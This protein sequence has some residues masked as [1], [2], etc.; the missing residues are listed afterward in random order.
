MLAQHPARR[1]TL[2]AFVLAALF[3][4]LAV[5]PTAYASLAPGAAVERAWQQ[6]RE[7]GAFAWRS[8]VTLTS[9]P[10][11]VL[12]N[13]GLNSTSQSL[14]AVGS[15]DFA[16]R[17]LELRLGELEGNLLNGAAGVELRVEDG[18]SRA[19]VDGGDWQELPGVGELFAPGAD[20]LGYL[21]AAEQVRLVGETDG[22]TQYA[23]E[24]SGPAFA[25]YMRAQLEQSLRDRGKLPAGVTVQTPEAY[26]ELRGSGM[27][28][29]GAD[30]L[31]RRQQISASL[32]LP[33]TSEAADVV[34]THS[35]SEFRE[36]VF[37]PPAVSASQA[38]GFGLNAALLVLGLLAAG[39]LIRGARS[40]RLYRALAPFFSVL[41]LLTPLLQTQPAAVAAAAVEE[42]NAE[43]AQAAEL[44]QEAQNP[45]AASFNP[46][47]QPGLAGASGTSGATG[48]RYDEAIDN[49]VDGDGDGLADA[50]EQQLGTSPTAK[51]SDGDGL[52][53]GV[54]VLEL[55][56]L[57]LQGDS[58]ADGLGDAQEVGGFELAGRRW[59]LDPLAGDTNHDGLPDGIEC[60]GDKGGAGRITLPCVDTDRDGLADVFDDDNDGD[61]LS[62]NLDTAPLTQI[63]PPTA[64]PNDPNTLSL[65]LAGYEPNRPLFVDFTVRPTAPAHLFYAGNVLDW[66]SGDRDGQ[67]QR[68]F[69]TTFGNSGKNANGDMRLVP[70]LEI[71]IPA[72]DGSFADLPTKANPSVGPLDSATLTS[73]RLEAWYDTWLDRNRLQQLGIT[74]RPKSTD[75]TL[76]A[77]VPLNSVRDPITGDPVA[78]SARMLYQPFTSDFGP[79]HKVRLIWLI[80]GM[81]DSCTAVPASFEPGKPD[82]ERRE[83]WC[84][85]TANWR[86]DP[87]AVL[88]S[89]YD[90][91]TVADLVVRED[92]GVAVAAAFQE[93]ATF[94]DPAGALPFAQHVFNLARGLDQTFMA[95]RVG[96]DGKSR[97]LTIA[98]LKAR[99]DKGQSC[100]NLVARWQ[101]PCDA[102]A[103][104]TQALTT[105]ADLALLPAYYLPTWLTEVYGGE[106]SGRAVSVREPTVLLARE[107]RARQ[108]A[109]SMGA[110]VV[111][112]GG[113]LTLRFDPQQQPVVMAGMALASYRYDEASRQ[114][115]DFP[116]DEAWNR[117]AT[118]YGD[119][120][121]QYAPWSGADEAGQSLAAGGAAFARGLFY[122]FEQGAGIVV[123]EGGRPSRLAGG[124][125]DLAQQPVDADLKFAATEP[126]ALAEGALALATRVIDL[127]R[128][129]NLIGA[130]T[131]E[132]LLRAV[133]ARQLWGRQSEPLGLLI[134]AAD[135]LNADDARAQS[136]GLMAPAAL[137]T[138]QQLN[139]APAAPLSTM[140]RAMEIGI[141]AG[142][143]IHKSYGLYSTI[144][145]VREANK[146]IA[147]GTSPYQSLV[148]VSKQGFAGK[149]LKLT[150]GRMTVLIT[151]GLAAFQ[152]YQLYS[153]YSQEFRA[154]NPFAYGELAGQIASMVA[155]T[156]S[157][158]VLGLV[159]PL[160][161]IAVAVLGLVD[162][163]LGATCGL[164]GAKGGICEGVTAWVTDTVGKF[165]YDAKPYPQLDAKDLMSIANWRITPK[166]ANGPKGIFQEGD[167]LNVQFDVITRL[168]ANPDLPATKLAPAGAPPGEV[169]F[170]PIDVIPRSNAGYQIVLRERN[171]GKQDLATGESN[172]GMWTLEP[173]QQRLVNTQ[174]VANEEIVLQPGINWKPGEVAL[175][176]NYAV[177][178]LECI[179]G[180]CSDDDEPIRKTSFTSLTEL[181]R[182]DVFPATL[183]RFYALEDRANGAGSFALAWDKQ[184]P[185]LCDA[186][187]DGL[188][189]PGCKGNDPADN[190][191][192]SDGDG[193]SD[194]YEVGNGSRGF[195]P[196][197]ADSDDDGLDDGAELRYGAD[198]GKADSDGDGLKDGDEIA[199]LNR[200]GSWAGGWAII[201]GYDAAGAPLKSYVSS[202]PLKAD[203]DDDGMLDKEEYTYGFNPRAFNRLDVLRVLTRIDE[204]DGRRD[205]IVAAGASVDYS[206]TIDNATRNRYAFGLLESALPPGVA[207]S[208]APRPYTLAPGASVTLGGALDLKGV[209]GSQKLAIVNRAGAIIADP[210][211]LTGGRVLWLHFDEPAGATRFADSSLFGND[212]SCAPG[213]CPV[214]GVE[215]YAGRAL[216]FEQDAA[217]P[218]VAAG[219][220]LNPQLRTITLWVRPKRSGAVQSLLA[221]EDY[222]LV[223]PGDSLRL[224]LLQNSNR[225]RTCF[226]FSCR[227]TS[228]TTTIDSAGELLEGQWN[229]VTITYDGAQLALYLNG[230]LDSRK[231]L[232]GPL[233]VTSTNLAIGR[234]LKGAL[235]ELAIY[236]RALSEAE[237]EALVGGPVLRLGFE[238]SLVDGSAMGQTV[239][240]GGDG[241]LR[242]AAERNGKVLRFDQRSW[243]ETAPHS[244]LD[245]GKGQG[246]FSFALWMQPAFA[247][248]NRDQDWLGVLG[249]ENVDSAGKPAGYAPSLFVNR[250]GDSL[251]VSFSTEKQRALP[252]SV[253][254]GP[255]LTPGAWQHVAVSYD[256][257]TFVFY[258]DGV[259]RARKP[260]DG[261]CAGLKPLGGDRIRIGRVDTRATITVSSLWIGFHNEDGVNEYYLT[262]AAAPGNSTRVWGENTKNYPA[263]NL[264]TTTVDVASATD[265][266]GGLPK[267]AVRF[268]LWESDAGELGRG[269]DDLLLD[270][271]APYRAPASSLGYN[272]AGNGKGVLSVVVQQSGFVGGLDD[273]RVYRHAL[274][275][276]EAREAFSGVSQAMGLALDEAPGAQQFRD[277][278]GNNQSALCSGDAC[279]Q[280]GL[281]GRVGQA[282]AFDG[283]DAIRVLNAPALNPASGLSVSAWVKLENPAAN[284]KIVSKFEERGGTRTG[285]ILGVNEGR[286]FA[287]I[288]DVDGRYASVKGGAVRADTWTHV[289]FTANPG[290]DLVGYVDGQPVGRTSLQLARKNIATV[291]NP[292]VILYQGKNFDGASREL[293]ADLNWLGSD[294]NDR[295]GSVRVVDA[296]V[297]FFTD[298]DYRGEQLGPLCAEQSLD[299]WS[300]YSCRNPFN[301]MGSISS[302]RVLAQKPVATG[303]GLR[304]TGANGWPSIPAAPLG[305]PALETL[306]IAARVK[307]NRL[308]GALLARAGWQMMI[309]GAEV[310]LSGGALGYAAVKAPLK[311]GVWQHV[312]LTYD[313]AKVV[314]YVDG[315]RAGESSRS[316]R[317][318]ESA[319][320]SFAINRG[321]ALDGT[322]KDLVLYARALDSGEIGELSRSPAGVSSAAR[323][324]FLPFDEPA[325]SAEFGTPAAAALSTNS[326][327]LTIGRASWGD[328]GVRGLIDEVTV[329]QGALTPE[330]IRAQ[331]DAAP[332][333]N[334]PLDE[335]LG[336]TGFANS[337]GAPAGC[338]GDACPQAG[339]KGRIRGA[340]VF[341]GVDDRV[342]TPDSAALDLGRYTVSLWVRPT[343]IKTTQD[344]TLVSKGREGGP[345][346]Y[347]LRLLAG[348]LR[349]ASST[350]CGTTNFSTTSRRALNQDQWNHVAVTFD[351]AQQQI[352][353]NGSL[354]ATVAVGCAGG[355]AA[356]NDAPLVLGRH[357]NNWDAFAGL[358]DEVQLYKVALDKAQI[359]RM[360]EY[361]ASW[362]DVVSSRNLSVDADNPVVRLDIGPA[363]TLPVG[364]ATIL[365]IYARDAGSPIVA[366]EYDAGAGWQSAGR[367]N[368]FWSLAYTP[369]AA[370]GVTIRL[371]A[372]DSVGHT[373]EQNVSLT[374]GDA[375]PAPTVA[376][377][378][379][380]GAAVLR[381]TPD[382]GGKAWK[383]ALAGTAANALQVV[384]EIRTL[385]G[386]V[387]GTPLRVAPLDGAWQGDYSFAAAPAGKYRLEVVATGVGGASARASAE[388]LLDN[389]AP[390][391][392][393]GAAP[394]E[395]GGAGAG[396]TLRGVVFDT[397]PLPVPALALRFEDA[398]ACSGAAC[399]G[400]QDGRIGSAAGFDG[401]DDG[402]DATINIPG[403]PFT[404]A[405]WLKPGDGR[406]Q[407]ALSAA[408]TAAANP[409]LRLQPDGGTLRAW[410][411]VD[412]VERELAATGFAPGE[413]RHAA[414]S[415]DGATAR[416]YV[417]GVQAAALSVAGRFDGLQHLWLG[418]DRGAERFAGALDELLVYRN[419][420]DAE[421]I[422]A[423]ADQ[424]AGAGVA[425]VEL[426]LQHVK[427]DGVV[428]GVVWTDAV[429]TGTGANHGLWSLALPDGLEGIYRVSLRL[430]DGAGNSVVQPNLWAG[431]VDTAAPRVRYSFEQSFWSWLSGGAATLACRV[432]DF[433]VRDVGELC[434]VGSSALQRSYAADAWYR[435]FFPAGKAPAR[436]ATLDTGARNTSGATPSQLTA[437]DSFGQ[438]TTAPRGQSAGI[439][440][441]A[442]AGVAASDAAAAMAADD[443]TAG[444]AAATGGPISAVLAPESGAAFNSAA[445]VTLSGAAF[446]PAPGVKDLAV[447]VNDAP[448]LARSYPS[449]TEA[450]TW[451]VDF[452]PPGDGI[453]AVQ[454]AAAGWD[455]SVITDTTGPRFVVDSRA[456]EVSLDAQTLT[457]DLIVRG[458]LTE[459]V[460]L[461]RLEARVDG[462]DWFEVQGPQ[463]GETS[464]VLRFALDEE[465]LGELTAKQTVAVD[466][467]V[468]DFAGNSGETSRALA[469]DV[470]PPNLEAFTLEYARD[471]AAVPLVDGAVITDTVNPT[472][473]AR[474][475]PADAADIASYTLTW[476]A[477]DSSASEQLR[478]EFFDAADS[479]DS[480]Q[481]TARRPLYVVLKAYDAAGNMTIAE[482]G[483]IYAD[484]GPTPS[485]LVAEVY[486]ADDPA[487]GAVAPY[488]GWLQNSCSLV[489]VDRRVPFVGEDGVEQ[490]QRLYATW[491]EQ[492]EPGLRL[493][494]SGAD[495]DTDGDLLVYLD[496]RPGGA[497]FNPY[498]GEG[499]SV[500][501]N[502]DPDVVIWVKDGVTAELLSFDDDLNQWN[503]APARFVLGYENGVPLTDV[504]VPFAD[505]GVT[506]PAAASL[507]LLALA[508]DD[509]SLTPWATMPSTNPALS[510]RLHNGEPLQLQFLNFRSV[511]T[512]A[513]LG[514]GI[515]PNEQVSGRASLEA[516]VRAGVP[517]VV[518]SWY[519][520]PDLV[521]NA[522]GDSEAYA[523]VL[524]AA[525]GG[526]VVEYTVTYANRG[527]GPSGELRFVLFG[528]A[529][530]RLED[531][532]PFG[533]GPVDMQP[534]T[535]PGLAPGEER[536]FSFRAIVDKERF[537]QYRDSFSPIW[538]QVQ[539]SVYEVNTLGEQTLV[540]NIFVSQQHDFDAPRHVEIREPVALVRPGVNSFRGVV[541]DYVGAASVEL[542][543]R[544]AGGSAHNLFC[545]D[546]TPED[547]QWSCDVDLGALADGAPV[548][549]RVRATDP[550]GQTGAWSGWTGFVA[551]AAAPS[552]TLSPTSRDALADGVIGPREVELSGVIG[553]GRLPAAVLV[554]DQGSGACGEAELELDATA[555]L[556]RTLRLEDRPAEP[557]ALGN[558]TVPACEAGA[559][560]QRSFEVGDELTVAD[561][562]LGLGLT[563][564]RHETLRATLRAPDGTAAVLI[565]GSDGG[566]GR[567]WS[568][569]LDDAAWRR[570]A[571]DAGVHDALAPYA[572]NPRSPAPGK[573]EVF[574]GRPAQGVW[575]L[576]LCLTPNSMFYGGEAYLGA[577]LVLEARQTPANVT[578]GWRYTLP[579]PAGSDGVAASFSVVGV[580]AVGNRGEP[581]VLAPSLDDTAPQLTLGTATVDAAGRI[582]LAGEGVDASGIGAMRLVMRTPGGETV[583]ERI[584]A[585]R[586]A[587][588]GV[589]GDWF[590]TANL[591]ANSW[592]H[593]STPLS[594]PGVYQLWV[595]A[596]D[597]AGNRLVSPAGEISWMQPATAAR[598]V[599]LPLI[600]NGDTPRI[601]TVLEELFLPLV[602][603]GAAAAQ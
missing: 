372:T 185:A 234:A 369:S 529:G 21:A 79:A 599:F 575:T 527:E 59:Y 202:D 219:E 289:A 22:E 115:K 544:A 561:V 451:T 307:L 29:I 364:R 143:V 519:R 45:P 581:L 300:C 440:S 362:L 370:G 554:C 184:F 124:A 274:T 296:C 262:Y 598:P 380:L 469:V 139:V 93:P 314:V 376:I 213:S 487:N 353:V 194:F 259:E 92:R 516:E 449:G 574:N 334:L 154:G 228:D 549:V 403:A 499:P 82:A 360:Y 266:G 537:E 227:W 535:L 435:A 470:T 316:G 356:G 76:L 460:G 325:G 157:L 548:E 188:R 270:A 196:R 134:G 140:D 447:T 138:L 545:A 442:A 70:M 57:P 589:L 2:F 264:F 550:N 166:D 559:P 275:P 420:L 520:T 231:A 566:D 284:Q 348:S 237:I 111:A 105:T 515:C 53:D 291:G 103:V 10:L 417:D 493:T 590:A 301:W 542:E 250:R 5:G 205:G 226:L 294:W 427:D 507:K 88:H 50:R 357:F 48:Y 603:R 486:R 87:S 186:D 269:D 593:A 80:Q 459:T 466:V 351:G 456:P 539:V 171:A 297:V 65:T 84:K 321:S 458:V 389:L 200:G 472:L 189:S 329:V 471:G 285:Y 308:Q 235:D 490:P 522:A 72:K 137:V 324:F 323:L 597:A 295:V 495:W 263:G 433:S 51:D 331:V 523:T 578:A 492:G 536:S 178:A 382:A 256:L 429:L 123:E 64:N 149:N 407:T 116:R 292:R 306:T 28:W 230:R 173:E 430:T 52:S 86:T 497:F 327:E 530:L 242:Y 107:E 20:P 457:G 513:G 98:T 267:N 570:A 54:E 15:V 483:P 498:R 305:N 199:H 431:V 11:P 383:L 193:L 146:L 363:T 500:S 365:P 135:L 182:Y 563:G 384:A 131:A 108:V 330:Q 453:Y 176:Q 104:R 482:R 311:I 24:L 564:V 224:R 397:P 393:L 113:D 474:W 133:G 406:K 583:A 478:E 390:Q 455:G 443:G 557:I 102:L 35:F 151:V 271:L 41:L 212:A 538:G 251:K 494:W 286:L 511:F 573:L 204:R 436:L 441:F 379:A 101:I 248:N 9:R 401:Q 355:A 328:F 225:R 525:K 155:V 217:Y 120:L 247:A 287:E 61:G 4:A 244:S 141:P 462:G 408:A 233:T 333:F 434:G 298:A 425:K 354:D 444:I 463:P 450:V 322:L 423:L 409:G 428:D 439:Q 400:V 381:A 49:G 32:A 249:Y 551:D 438:C 395:L 524:P 299:N 501:G 232:T 37:A 229:H 160:G 85:N 181:L 595:E 312:A 223:V 601:E 388:L 562:N 218:T 488:H 510:S 419:A 44:R 304:F 254:S 421:L 89:Y 241:E 352:F 489:G 39:L 147:A 150:A 99:F 556:T 517:A 502:L 36:P 31:P 1:S 418:S 339:A 277:G 144:S 6:A 192:D 512:W 243:L 346:N 569:L 180:K 211:K 587:T 415:Y 531:R 310:A 12:E 317:L 96:V 13:V 385:A 461:L 387:A 175:V 25:E 97:D 215:G 163:L 216:Q 63:T 341:D 504:F 576:S 358:L 18:H 71:E 518:R 190:S 350:T 293:G 255:I 446:L 336:A 201:Y 426:G 467:R 405:V 422:R 152:T 179:A 209:T 206:A 394:A 136:R 161:T 596:E 368:E 128:Q 567:N 66:P 16:A 91:F 33:G 100:A 413:W 90:R 319:V 34:V 367:D 318:P 129:R 260:V 279:P 117:L 78:F 208:L 454:A 412:G 343:A 273:V 532:S 541:A 187:G 23:F 546:P 283:A 416:L 464:G 83:S 56:T 3:L 503:P 38:R 345:Y 586:G 42:L 373:A 132:D 77:Y 210:L 533:Y 278:S 170:N 399:P 203:S 159:V 338:A 253:E 62:D 214:A 127:Q 592:S 342:E 221:A 222:N 410:L 396:R 602:R 145:T 130:T 280:S 582:S 432:E 553:D 555:L 361:Q 577:A 347:R 392:E 172:R 366:V 58:D 288:W 167:R 476:L 26:R 411:R 404:V 508:V 540:D 43:A 484:P 303:D 40:R 479:A 169:S 174:T 252:C 445:A 55:G 148:E 386:A 332:V 340:L 309:D 60:I 265:F 110:N 68:V 14:Y 122:S 46:L 257:N 8:E 73:Q 547:K 591:A 258:V 112:A 402:L 198:P 67:Q 326:Q 496:S 240:K 424:Q 568:L 168:Y 261:G 272:Y 106:N 239:T 114:W 579:L 47:A 290:G 75:G 335:S 164:L 281:S 69:D 207:G 315:V 398:L 197:K 378:P 534:M 220:R 344:Q 475:R 121:R 552:V 377:S 191:A 594:E 485:P 195:D 506:D 584:D 236:D 374:A 473:A 337:A 268:Q 521:E 543:W 558:A 30:G 437:C 588:A 109:L 81:Q 282:T 302:V 153:K 19:R 526:D 560:F 74:V 585:P 246:H 465:R 162:A 528:Y 142:K 452:V 580:D 481:L 572:D 391:A 371:R 17:T 359:E 480:L 125:A 238:Q 118:L 126:Q 165:F 509:G 468:T 245:L 276:V 505:L 491:T 7:R 448:V 183:D 565:D 313:G 156:V 477:A 349:V 27:I 375:A 320:D 95:G 514:A 600:G 119:L 158:A 414:L 177:P 94:A 571:D